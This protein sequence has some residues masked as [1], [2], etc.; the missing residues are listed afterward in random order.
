MKDL[1]QKINPSSIRDGIIQLDNAIKTNDPNILLENM[2]TG[3]KEFEDRVGRR[4]TY[5]EMRQMWG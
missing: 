2:K 4:M 3:A 5:S 1:E